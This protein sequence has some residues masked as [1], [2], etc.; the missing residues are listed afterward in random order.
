MSF[1]NEMN[2]NELELKAVVAVMA[3]YV[4]AGAIFLSTM[5]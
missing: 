3:A 5:L 4:V 1:A 2:R